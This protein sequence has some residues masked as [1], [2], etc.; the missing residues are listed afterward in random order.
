MTIWVVRA[1]KYGER[2]GQALE[3]GYVFIGWVNLPDQSALS[4]REEL[5]AIV[6]ETHSDL[7]PKVVAN[8]T[9]QIWAFVK[10]I[11]KGDIVA[12]P[13]KSQ[14][15]IA[16]GEVIGD[17]EYKGENS[18]DARHCRRVKWINDPVKRASLDSDLRFSF[19]SALTVFSVHLNNA[20]ERIR[21][22]LNM[23]GALSAV[24]PVI[25]EADV[26]EE[27]P[28]DLMNAASQQISDF[29]GP[30]FKGRK[31]EELVNAILEA[32]GYEAEICPMGADE[33]VDILAGHVSPAPVADFDHAGF[34]RAREDGKNI[35]NDA[36]IG[37]S[38]D[39]T[40]HLRFVAKHDPSPKEPRLSTKGKTWHVWTAGR[41]GARR[42]HATGQLPCLP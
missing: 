42:K 29:I 41:F 37:N 27:P 19:G 6:A 34:G 16:F 28:I 11:V 38:A 23:P 24:K 32:K 8:H 2:E 21:A 35:P 22:T 17:Y 7:S 18:A 12:L 40:V 31:M 5:R 10:R 33:G 9:G 20:E 36:G 3:E 39:Q 14:P 4:D 13:L 1:G 25:D 15:A 30:K 26:D